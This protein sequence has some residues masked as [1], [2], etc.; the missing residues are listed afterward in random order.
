MR[1]TVGSEIR[2]T[3]ALCELFALN[4]CTDGPK[5]ALALGPLSRAGNN[6]PLFHFASLSLPPFP[7]SSLYM[8]AVSA[9]QNNPIIRGLA[10]RLEAAGKPPKVIIVAAMRKLLTI[11]NAMVRDQIQWLQLKIVQQLT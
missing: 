2:R 8:A 4:I 1:P 10:K 7:T 9:I 5:P 6:S 11:I 3:F